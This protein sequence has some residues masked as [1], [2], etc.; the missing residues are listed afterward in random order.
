ME[1]AVGEERRRVGVEAVQTE[2][3]REQVEGA[4]MRVDWMEAALGKSKIWT[5]TRQRLEE[6]SE[7]HR[8]CPG[9][10]KCLVPVQR[11]WRKTGRTG[12]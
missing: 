4:E 12:I 1:V 6:N 9:P 3:L 7:I 8:R 11:C 2:E 5:H 10:E